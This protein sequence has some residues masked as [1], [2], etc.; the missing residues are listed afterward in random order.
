MQTKVPKLARNVAI[1]GVGISK[2]GRQ[3][4]KTGRDLFLQAFLESLQSVDHGIYP[5]DIESL[6]LGNYSGDTFEKQTHLGPLM[7]DWIGLPEI[8]ATR[9]ENACASSGAAFRQG[10]MAIASG[11]HEIVL[12]G[13][14][15][16]MTDLSL[17]HATDSLAL[18]ADKVFEFENAALTF[19]GSFAI[20]ASAYMDRYDISPENLMKVAIKNHENG[21]L[22]PKA[23]L[24]HTITELMQK[25]VQDLKKKG[26]STPNWNN[27]I[28]FLQDEQINPTIAWPLK[29]FDCS[30]ISD[31]AS[32]LILTSEEVAS[33]FTNIPV[34]VVASVQT[35]A[36]SL[37]NREDLTS[38]PSTKQ[39]AQLAYTMAGIGPDDI[40]FSEVHDC[41]TI[42]EVIAT[43]DLGYFPPGY[44]AL[45]V[46]EGLTNR[47]GKKPINASGGLK[48]K[49]HPVGATGV[50]QIAEIWMQLRG[51]AGDRQITGKGLQYGLAQNLGGSG[52]SSLVTILKKGST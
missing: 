40:D 20:M 32:C 28:D 21:S 25:S 14:V 29:L 19:T 11:M 4:K 10:V 22:N 49:G 7:A 50:A 30:P 16:K 51:E 31:G 18:A 36:A 42:A 45:A 39:A 34:S 46:A 38:I 35:S 3:P 13:G 41:F 27:E 5:R 43:E 2:F 26:R 24:N 12:V 52:N 23:Q 15:E 6:F 9:I 17:T 44:G 8:P 33:S 37:A 48:S 1:V 47:D